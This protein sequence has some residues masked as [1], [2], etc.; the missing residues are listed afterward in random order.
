MTRKA[1]HIPAPHRLE[2]RCA[3]A[4][5]VLLVLLVLLAPVAA[6][7]QSRAQGAQPF[8]GVSPEGITCLIGG[9]AKSGLVEGPAVAPDIEPLHE[10]TL[11][12]PEGPRLTAWSRGKPFRVGGKGE[13]EPHFQVKLPLEPA[14]LGPYMLAISGPK[15]LVAKKLPGDLEILPPD[16]SGAVALVARYLKSKGLDAQPVAIVQ[17]FRVD[18]NGDGAKDMLVN[19][20]NTQRTTAS[21]GEYAVVLARLA[22]APGEPAI[23][24]AEDITPETT[25]FQSTLWENTIVAIADL[26]GDGAMEIV[27]YGEF[28]RGEGWEVLRIRNGK[29]DQPLFCGCG[30]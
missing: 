9:A 15:R 10:F 16:D 13:C 18:L 24:L 14:Q 11:I 1:E 17:A 22:G 12:T 28:F 8:V 2:G 25:S 23:A 30:G 4:L 20:I 26:D 7:P 19:A 5:L 6:P 29:A 3:A 27:V 21:A